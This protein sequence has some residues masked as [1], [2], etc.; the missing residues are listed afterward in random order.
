MLAA[1]LPAM[2]TVYHLPQSLARG[3]AAML[4]RK[5][6]PASIEGFRH[7]PA[8]GPAL[9]CTPCQ[10][11]YEAL[12]IQ[13]FCPRRIQFVLMNIPPAIRPHKVCAW[14]HLHYVSTMEEGAMV[15]AQYLQAGEMACIMNMDN[16]YDKWLNALHN[17]PLLQTGIPLLPVSMAN[18]IT[19]ADALALSASAEQLQLALAKT[20][21]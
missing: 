16:E 7:L 20:G 10:T 9:L 15:I 11:W 18:D 1:L 3:C 4:A 5:N 2:F 17:M 21:R 13:M 12:Y 19:V 14:L 6:Y 8:Q